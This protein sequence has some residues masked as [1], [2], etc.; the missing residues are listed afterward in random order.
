MDLNN[1]V[2]DTI[3]RQRLDD[4]RAEAHRVALASTPRPLRVTLG[5]A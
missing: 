2:I 3:V 1:Y 5:L 4:L